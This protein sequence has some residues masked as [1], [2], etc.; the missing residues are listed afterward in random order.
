[1]APGVPHTRTWSPPVPPPPTPG[2]SATCPRGLSRG[3]GP[4]GRGLAPAP[5]ARRPSGRG[6]FPGLRALLTEWRPLCAAPV[7]SGCLSADARRVVSARSAVRIVLPGA[8]TR[9]TVFEHLFSA[10]PG[11]RPP[12]RGSAPRCSAFVSLGGRGAISRPGCRAARDVS[13][14]HSLHGA[15]H[16]RYFPFRFSRIGITPS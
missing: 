11:T 14:S 7:A 9:E 16:T 4:A 15:L 2:A 8:F 13:R 1:M 5:C 12:R 6:V 10:L 3:R